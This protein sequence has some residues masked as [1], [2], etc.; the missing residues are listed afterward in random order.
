MSE[1]LIDFE[2]GAMLPGTPYRVIRKIG[3]GG[4]GAVFEVEHTRLKKR[5]MAKTMHPGL[6]A[7][8]DFVTRMEVEAQTLARI[9]HPNIVQVHDLGVTDDG[10][11]FFVMEKLEGS[12]LRKLLRTR[13][14]LD[15]RDALAIVEDVLEGLAH[16]HREGVVHRD[17]KPENIFLARSGA[18]TVTK[19]LDF[20]IV[21]VM[22]DSKNLTGERF[23]G[24]CQYA[25]PEQLRGEKPSERTDIY[26]VG[27]VLF[28]LLTGRRV[29]AGPSTREFMAQH[30][31]E[32]AP[33]L[34]SIAQGVPPELDALVASS[35]AKDPAQRP[36]GA[37]WFAS[38][39]H[40][41]QLSSA[42]VVLAEANTTA[43]ML[44]NG[45]GEGPASSNPILLARGEGEKETER[46]P[47][48]VAALSA[49]TP[50]PH[51]GA[52]P[53]AP[54][55]PDATDLLERLG[56][57]TSEQALRREQPAGDG[58]DVVVAAAR[59]A[60]WRVVSAPRLTA[61]P[62]VRISR[63]RASWRRRR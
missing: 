63:F 47:R 43:E 25:A 55:S 5:L 44:L 28:E 62:P 18:D 53:R 50:A 12:D 38:Q 57:P 35:L 15:L 56:R 61:R 46:D 6:R 21:H 8:Q 3:A 2:P 10:I 51:L 4:M 34:S 30:M 58:G 54:G 20:G 14:F 36:I 17:I 49:T 7:R 27:C 59:S 16:A 52:S 23:L 9:G 22:N 40:R 26:A 13:R 41:I 33:L 45:L 37:L 19:I 32:E 1:D 31:H 29:F 60:A 24:T 42:N 39:L 11:P 48:L